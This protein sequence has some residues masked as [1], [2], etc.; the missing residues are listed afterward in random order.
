MEQIP[1]RKSVFKILITRIFIVVLIINGVLA[2]IN[3]FETVKSQKEH[4]ASRRTKIIEELTTTSDFLESSLESIQRLF[5]FMQSNA[6]QHLIDLGKTKD[7]KE[8]DLYDQLEQI[9]L[10]SIDHDFY[11]IRNAIIVNTTAPA[12]LGLDFMNFGE[13]H[14]RMLLDVEKSGEFFQE[15]FAFESSTKRLRSFSYQATADKKYIVEIGSY[16]DK[17]DEMMKILRNR[18]IKIQQENEDI[19]SVNLWRGREGYQNSFLEDSLA[20]EIDTLIE[21]VFKEKNDIISEFNFGKRQINAE[22]IYRA[23]TELDPMV[24]SLI[25][26]ITDR[27]VP[28]YK[29]IIKQSIY[30]LVFL[31]FL[32]LLITFATR[33]FRRVLRDLLKKTVDIA[34]GELDERVEEVGENEFTTLAEQFN[35]MVDRLEA[36]Y[37]ELYQQNEEITAQ[38]DEIEKQRNVALEQKEVIEEQKQEIVDS[39][40]YAQKIQ[41]AILPSDAALEAVMPEHFVLFKPRDIVSGDFYWMKQVKDFVFFVA[42][43]CTGHGVPGAFMS[44]LGISFLNEIVSKG[45]VDNSGDILN[46]MR[47]K[48]KTSLHQVGAKNEQKD[49]MDLVLAVFDFKNKKVQYSGAYN[50]LIVVRDNELIEYKGDKQPIAIHIVEKDFTT[51]NIDLQTNDSV[52]MFSDGYA[53]QIGGPKNRKFMVKNLKRMLVEINDKPMLEQKK[54]LDETIEDWMKDD[55]QVDDIVMFGAKIQ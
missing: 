41:Q 34:N 40:N 50:S 27:N 44:M 14:I 18:L 17:A 46:A 33:S 11:V 47:N 28:I 42:A 8:V 43:D 13:E 37:N 32:F 39:I 3:I 36:S 15:S 53:D 30:S 7:L 22:F 6:A 24:I 2:I 16:S 55:S 48:I 25:T 29:I 12:D 20:F 35:R 31:G 49:G 38:R 21:K 19:L 4:E 52:Y 26:D 5:Y 10:D 23:S 51:H 45:R 9:G 1:K 54:F